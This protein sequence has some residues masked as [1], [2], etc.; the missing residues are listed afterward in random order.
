M[1][2]LDLRSGTGAQNIGGDQKEDGAPA[3]RPESTGS[4][5]PFEIGDSGVII[6]SGRD[7]IFANDSIDFVHMALRKS[8]LDDTAQR[9]RILP[10]DHVTLVLALF[11]TG[12]LRIVEI[13]LEEDGRV[14]VDVSL[15]NGEA[16]LLTLHVAM[17]ES[18]SSGVLLGRDTGISTIEG[19]VSKILSH[20]D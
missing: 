11:S 14:V 20:V 1:G 18:I 15:L 4:L 17:F 10:I 6:V 9:P 13:F 16:T 12:N 19:E 3:S 8:V 7:G 2:R 5:S